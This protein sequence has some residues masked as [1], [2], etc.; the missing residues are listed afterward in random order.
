[1]KLD[2]VE[3]VGVDSLGRLHVKPKNSTFPTVAAVAKA[4]E[5][6]P[7]ARTLVASPTRTGPRAYEEPYTEIYRAAAKLGVY[8]ALS[9]ET[10]CD[11][12]SEWVMAQL[13]MAELHR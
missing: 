10:R 4:V 12:E 6:N 5:W 3:A 1:M 8:L 2:Y 7:L 13:K 11:K 9:D